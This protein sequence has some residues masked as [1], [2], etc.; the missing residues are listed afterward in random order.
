M[1]A[2]IVNPGFPISRFQQRQRQSCD[3]LG[4]SQNEGDLRRWPLDWTDCFCAR[5][6]CSF[7]TSPRGY[8]SLYATICACSLWHSWLLLQ[9]VADSSAVRGTRPSQPFRTMRSVGAVMEVRKSGIVLS[10]WTFE[11]EVDEVVL[12]CVGRAKEDLSAFVDDQ[13]LVKQ[14]VRALAGL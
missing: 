10:R 3:L 2:K 9:H 6:A 8:F 13:H 11:A 4:V 7:S 12:G 5:K 14:V 1:R